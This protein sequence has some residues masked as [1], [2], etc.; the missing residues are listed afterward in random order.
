MF[1]RCCSSVPY[2]PV[3]HVLDGADPA[4][5][6]ESW[7]IP[8]PETA[9]DPGNAPD[10][11]WN[12]FEAS[13]VYRIEMRSA[14]PASTRAGWF[15]ERS[16]CVIQVRSR[17]STEWQITPP[18]LNFAIGDQSRLIY[19]PL[20][21]PTTTVYPDTAFQPDGPSN[22]PAGS[23]LLGW[24][25]QRF[26][27][28]SFEGYEGGRPIIGDYGGGG[29]SYQECLSGGELTLGTFAG[30]DYLMTPPLTAWLFTSN[31]CGSDYL[32]DIR[33]TREWMPHSQGVGAAV[34]FADGYTDGYFPPDPPYRPVLVYG[35]GALLAK[36]TEDPNFPL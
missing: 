19:Y 29:R 1:G 22:I 16:R 27:D 18:A 9:G 7:R 30:R 10:S 5:P 36:V 34:G 12:I 20:T 28:G 21:V 31:P 2:P 13:K 14:F 6:R 15:A 3:S 8:T 33:I 32:A 4:V 25:V 17:Q 26:L 24:T 11:Y 23:E 35:R